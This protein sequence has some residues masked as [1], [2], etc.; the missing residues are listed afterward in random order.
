MRKQNIVCSVVFTLSCLTAGFSQV[1]TWSS[2]IARI[3]YANCTP[4]HHPGGLAPSSFMTY[5]HVLPYAGSISYAVSNRIMPPWPADPNYKRYAHDNVLTPNEISLIQQWVGNGAPSGDLRFAPAPPEYDNFSQLGTVDLSIRMPTFV[6]PH[7]GDVYRN[8]S[9]NTGLTQTQYVTAIEVI[10]GNKSIVHHVLVYMDT[11]NNAIDPNSAGGTGSS[12]SKLIY[13]Y[14]PGS[15]PYFTPPGAGFKFPPN[16]RIIF[17]M[18]YAPGSMGQTDS[19][20][21]NFKLTSTPLRQIAVM[22]ILNHLTSLTNGPLT[23]PANTTKTFYEQQYINGNWTL[24]Y[25]WPHMHLIGRSIKTFATTLSNDTIRFV[26][27]PSWNF[28]WQ[29]NYVFANTIKIPHG[30]TMRA[31]AF[32]DNTANNPFNPNSPPQN[33]SAGEGTGDE[34]MMVF[35]A[36]MPYQNGD[37]YLIVDKRILPR[38]GTTFCEGQSVLLETIEGVGYSYQWFRNGAPISG[39]TS[40]SYT[41][42]ESGSYTVSITLGPNSVV[43]DPVTV[44]VR[45]APTASVT[46]NGPT[47]LC[48]GESTVLQA[49]I[50]PNYSYRWFKDG[51]L[52]SNAT[53]STYTATTPG[54]YTVEVY[55]GCYAVSSPVI[56]TSASSPNI[57]PGGVVHLCEGDTVTLT[58]SAGNGYLWSDGSTSQSITVTAAGTYT[59]TVSGSGCAGTASVEVVVHDNPSPPVI[60]T[61][62]NVLIS[63]PATHYQWYLDGFPVGTDTQEFTAMQ[64]GCYQ[65]RITDMNGCSAFSDTVCML[66]TGIDKYRPSPVVLYPN[67]TNEKLYVN[68]AE[69]SE[70]AWIVLYDIMGKRIAQMKAIRPLTEMDT[71]GLP[72]GVYIV[73]LRTDSDRAIHTAKLLISR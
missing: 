3:I 28:H 70:V 54:S 7:N 43:S 36:F 22:P 33:V 17:Q 69:R 21:I 52:L 4:C 39:A 24:L 14:V 10:P 60:T 5:Q 38:S 55:N 56:I 20:R 67:P 45:T 1:P 73:S 48:S 58:A 27:I 71:R 50:G 25:A 42:T 49:A 26:D 6:V 44:T 66:V 9:M 51:I 35:F 11:S 19:T 13:G 29:M 8:F 57:I 2:D 32:Y 62:G 59:V 63:A 68:L 23:I 12:A 41:A 15:Q 46:V 64:S 18:H 72:K 65:V 30:S 53:S 40:A 34:M 37:E 47:A 61:S 31:V 16:T